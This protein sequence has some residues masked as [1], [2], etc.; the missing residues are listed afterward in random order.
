MGDTAGM[1]KISFNRKYRRGYISN[2]EHDYCRSE[3]LFGA[4]VTTYEIT[5]EKAFTN[6]NVLFVYIKK[7]DNYVKIT[8]KKI[9]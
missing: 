5:I 4:Q 8:K 9:G 1:Y 2:I 6:D 7:Y 3:I